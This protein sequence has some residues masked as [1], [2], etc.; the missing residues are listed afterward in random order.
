MT[1]AT[2]CRQWR[3]VAESEFSLTETHVW[4][5]VTRLNRMCFGTCSE[6]RIPG[7]ACLGFIARLRR[8]DYAAH[9]PRRKSPGAVSP[10]KTF[11]AVDITCV[12]CVMSF[13][14]S[15]APQHEISHG[16]AHV[17]S[18]QY[19]SCAQAWFPCAHGDEMGSRSSEP[20]SQKGPQGVDGC[21]SEQVQHRRIRRCRIRQTHQR[22]QIL[23]QHLQ[24]LTPAHG[25]TGFPENVG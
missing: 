3:S 19:P 18:P 2:A 8:Y 14:L 21:H 6:T 7:S 23:H 4:P 9:L 5:Y 12:R 20:P 11:S 15:F 22:L 25:R 1:I 17:P 10:D 13:R 24:R 16:Q